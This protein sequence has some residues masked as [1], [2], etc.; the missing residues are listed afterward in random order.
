[1]KRKI[2]ALLLI[3][4]CALELLRRNSDSGSFTIPRITRTRYYATPN[5]SNNSFN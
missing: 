1:M 4:G 3:M 2:L 5:F